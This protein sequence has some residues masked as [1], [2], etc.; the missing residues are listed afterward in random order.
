[1]EERIEHPPPYILPASGTHKQTL[2]LL[3]GTSTSGPEFA[4]TFLDF[5][6]LLP[7]STSSSSPNSLASSSSSPLKRNNLW[8][9]EMEGLLR[10]TLRRVLSKGGIL[11]GVRIVFPTGSLK[12]T[13]VFGGRKTNAW[14]DVHDFSDRTVGEEDQ[15][16]GMKESLCYLR[17]LVKVEV[18]ILE[19]DD[20]RGGRGGRGKV[21]LGGF[22]QGCA[23][24]VVGLLSGE[25]ESLGLGGFVG[26]SG[27]LPFR[28]Q[29]DEAI[30]YREGSDVESQIAK[31]L[32]RV[33]RKGLRSYLRRLWTVFL[34]WIGRISWL[35]PWILRRHLMKENAGAEDEVS[36]R[37][38]QAVQYIR[39]LLSLPPQ[40]LDIGPQIPIL[41]GHGAEDQKVKHEWALQMQDTLI[42]MGLNV[43]AR[44]YEGVAHWYCEEEMRDLVGFLGFEGKK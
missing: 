3:H 26:F 31:K 44:R 25:F 35:L 36:R 16:R 4:E 23:M 9:P 38:R 12:K 30:H 17:E 29:V 15:V 7:L 11:E 14:F 41:L 1:M 20:G 13:T 21:V 28:R 37:R 32:E 8:V 6:F 33:R 18:K 2:I 43:K 19:K 40:T 39:T 22:S 27:W 42:D 5:P 10:T 24:G 34:R